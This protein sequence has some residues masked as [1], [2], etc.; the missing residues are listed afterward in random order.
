MTDNAIKPE[1]LWQVYS[2]A[3]HRMMFLGGAL[4]LVLTI[5][6]WLVELAGRYTGLSY[7]MPLSIPATWAHAYL[8]LFGVF[9]FFTFGLLIV[10]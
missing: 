9:P 1:S 2:C 7:E 4:Q 5:A 8:M 3:P 6:F 10:L